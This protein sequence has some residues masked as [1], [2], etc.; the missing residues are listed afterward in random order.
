M[1]TQTMNQTEQA[2][3]ALRD[4][5]TDLAQLEAKDISLEMKLG[6][7]RARA[8]MGDKK[9][10]AEAGKI[11]MER[12]KL[13]S[14]I[15]SLR[16]ERLALQQHLQ[17]LEEQGKQEHAE[18]LQQRWQD[19][20]AESRELE[21]QLAEHVIAAARTAQ[22]LQDLS[23]E[24]DQMPKA[25]A[26]VGVPAEAPGRP[27][28]PAM[29]LLPARVISNPEAEVAWWRN[30]YIAPTPVQKATPNP[31]IAAMNVEK[32]IL[33]KAREEERRRNAEG[34]TRFIVKPEDQFRTGVA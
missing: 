31:R 28:A 17:E 6:D 18:A 11:S 25:L 3:K 13:S 8:R 21:E 24:F 34:G 10:Q 33:A 30:K 16:G 19:I 26:Q 20:V 29:S 1:A 22:R 14:E 32:E 23:V 15:D 7:A 9:A 12:A 2:T 27:P 5:E 4:V